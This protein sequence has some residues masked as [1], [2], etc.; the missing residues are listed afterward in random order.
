[1]TNV[2]LP[3]TEGELYCNVWAA[4]DKQMFLDEALDH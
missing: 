3:K 2:Y 4:V 1:V